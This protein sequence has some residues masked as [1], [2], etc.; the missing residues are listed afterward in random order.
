MNSL[1]SI[2]LTH[3]KRQYPTKLKEDEVGNTKLTCNVVKE[4]T[5]LGSFS[6]EFFSMDTFFFFFSKELIKLLSR[7]MS[8]GF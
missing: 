3:F 6:V 5:L 1:D 8:K 7:L 2:S 4:E